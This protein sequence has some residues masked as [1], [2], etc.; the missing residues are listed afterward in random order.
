MALVIDIETIGQSVEEIHP[1]ALEYLFRGLRRDNAGE[2]EVEA[3]RK[4]M[5]ERFSL[6]PTTGKVICIGLLDTESGE[7]KA[8]VDK[9]ETRLLT[10]FWGYLSESPPELFVTFNGKSFD[11]PFLNIRSAVCRVP[12]SMRLPVRRYTAHP[13][14]DLREALAGGDRHRRGSLD[15]FCAVFGIPSPKQNLDGAGVGP[16]FR[17]GRIDEIARYCLGDCRAT[18]ALFERLKPFYIDSNRL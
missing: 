5:V 10:S 3:R 2:D 13:H 1:R 18:A 12:P 14:L 15:Y 9:E 16:A 11:F 17:Q 7:E 4:E 8:L 6:D